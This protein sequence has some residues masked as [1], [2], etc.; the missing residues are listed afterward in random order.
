[1][2]YQGPIGKM[3]LGKHVH[4]S[5]ECIVCTVYD[6]IILFVL[7]QHQEEELCPS[8]ATSSQCDKTPQLL[9]ILSTVNAQNGQ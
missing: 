3:T 8:P 4:V 9:R 6:S 7:Q 2:L 5:C 1:M